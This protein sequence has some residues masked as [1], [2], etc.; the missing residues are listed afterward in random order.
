MENL[1]LIWGNPA[2]SRPEWDYIEK[3]YAKNMVKNQTKTSQI[4]ILAFILGSLLSGAF[5]V[6]R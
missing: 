6:S 1:S 3:H 5:L 4:K 2:S